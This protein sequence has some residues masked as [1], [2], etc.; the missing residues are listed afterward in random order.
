[1]T[2]IKEMAKNPSVKCPL[3]LFKK[4]FTSL[5]DFGNRM[6]SPFLIGGKMDIPT[7]EEAERASDIL[8][9]YL[10]SKSKSKPV[11]E[12]S[13][14]EGWMLSTDFS[15]TWDVISSTTVRDILHAGHVRS[16]KRGTN[17]FFSEEEMIAFILAEGCL[18]GFETFT[19]KFRWILSLSSDKLS[20][21]RQVADSTTR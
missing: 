4:L 1:M 10:E 3:N 6:A 16:V 9:R 19:R 5:S 20:K 18:H 21:L 12:Q 8:S 11:Q 13:I 14:P 15:R 2:I 17:L 7:Y